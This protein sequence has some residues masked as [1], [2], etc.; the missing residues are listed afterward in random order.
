MTTWKG[1]L[2]FLFSTL[3]CHAFSQGYNFRN[4]NSTDGLTQPFVYS[5]IQ[6][7]HGNLWVGTGDGLFRYNGFTFDKY[8]TTD[9][10]ADNFITCTISDGENMWLGHSNGRISYF[11]GK[12]F[13]SVNISQSNLSRITHFSK[14]PDG[15]IWAS[16]YSDGLFELNEEKGLL[17][18]IL[19]KDRTLIVS[20]TF[21]NDN[22]LLVGTNTGLLYCRLKESGEIEIIRR[23]EEIPESKVT[24]IQK[25]RN[26]SGFYIATENDGIFK[27]INEDKLFNVSKITADS[28]SEITG[29]QEI[30]EDS[31][32]D[33]WLGSFGNGLTKMIFSPSGELSKINYF[34]NLNGFVT[35]NVKTIFEDR[36]GN[37]WSGN[38]GQG[39]TLITP[40]TFSVF[41]FDPL[42][43]NDIFL[44]W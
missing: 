3:A 11:N 26:K 27:L 8:T 21:L 42:Y 36:E 19:F 32:S 33:I 30:Y 7:V 34:N 38:Y 24:C 25:M 17:K 31:H 35:N 2:I 4:F 20:F 5:I 16:S 40:K 18:H 6:D 14:S 39:L 28:Y 37:I 44:F 10:L 23:I 43:G 12:I 29:I 9:S 13:H 15:Q 22:E 41:K 1:I